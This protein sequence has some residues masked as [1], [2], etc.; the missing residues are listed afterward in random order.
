[1]LSFS[2]L[3]ILAAPA[4]FLRMQDAIWQKTSRVSEKYSWR[5]SRTRI[6]TKLRTLQNLQNFVL[7]L[8]AHPNTLSF[9]WKY[10]FRRES[11]DLYVFD[12]KSQLADLHRQEIMEKRMHQWHA[13]FVCPPPT[14]FF[15]NEN[16]P[17]ILQ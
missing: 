15:V 9:I 6:S 3:V 4:W 16:S 2:L 11:K 13:C 8:W 1:M 14:H 17:S 12:Y 10:Y 7:V 5:D